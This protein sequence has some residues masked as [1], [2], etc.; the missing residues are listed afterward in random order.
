MIDM[1]DVVDTAAKILTT[2]GHEGKTYAL[3][4]PASISIHDVASGLSNALGKEVKYVNVPLEAARA[5]MIGMGM[6]EWL[7]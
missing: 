2:A 1:R 6:T 4:G 3:T 7:A 5:S